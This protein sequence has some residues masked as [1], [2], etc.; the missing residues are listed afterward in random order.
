M[1][2]CGG[3]VGHP[4]GGAGTGDRGNS[5]GGGG[6]VYVRACVGG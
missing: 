3:V 5:R 2:V 1:W 6:G 4:G